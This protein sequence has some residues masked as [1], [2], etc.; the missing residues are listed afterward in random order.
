MLALLFIFIVK[1]SHEFK[2]VHSCRTWLYSLFPYQIECCTETETLRRLLDSPDFLFRFDC[3]CPMASSSLT[4]DDRGSLI[5][6]IAMHFIIYSQKAELDDIKHGLDDV[7]NFGDLIRSHPTLFKPLFV[8]SGRTVLHAD[9]FLTLFEIEY[10]LQGSNRRERE[11]DIM[12][13]LNYYIQELEG[14][15][16]QPGPPTRPW[17][18]YHISANLLYVR[19][20]HKETDPKVQLVKTR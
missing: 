8:A 14:T 15:F 4:L 16:Q 13:H 11:E 10:S 1:L 17:F 5:K 6:S 2:F 7:L 19:A 3:G 18:L 9:S 12:L 20:S